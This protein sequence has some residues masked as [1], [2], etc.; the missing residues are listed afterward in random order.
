MT[1]PPTVLRGNSGRGGRLRRGGAAIAGAVIRVSR[2]IHHGSETGA[3]SLRAQRRERHGD[4]F[5]HEHRRHTS[6]QRPR[7]AVR[8]SISRVTAIKS[9]GVGIGTLVSVT[10][11]TV[12]DKGTTTCLILLPA[13]RLGDS[14]RASFRTI[15]ITTLAK[16]TIAGPPQGAQQSYKVIDLRGSAKLVDFNRI[17]RGNRSRR[18]PEPMTS[19]ST[20]PRPPSSFTP[21]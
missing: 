16:T 6:V 17:R 11:A 8:P 12:P 19:T 10:I 2:I 15:G 21:S 7:R 4:V 3:E 20:A 1:R 9:E 5:D 14:K 18:R 13:I